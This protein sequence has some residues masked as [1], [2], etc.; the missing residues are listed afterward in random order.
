MSQSVTTSLKWSEMIEPIDLIRVSP[1]LYHLYEANAAADPTRIVIEQALIGSSPRSW[2]TLTYQ[3]LSFQIAK[4]R[5]FLQLQGIG[6]LSRCSICSNTCPEWLI[7]DLAVLSLGAAT[8]SIYTTLPTQD[9]AYIMKD[10]NVTVAIVENQTLVDQFLKIHEGFQGSDENWYPPHPLTHIICIQPCTAHPLVTSLSDIVA[11]PV[12]ENTT[13][14]CSATRNSFASLVYTSGSTGLPK[15]V[16]QTHGNHLANLEQVVQADV[17]GPSGSLFLYL[18][19]AHSFARLVGYLGLFTDTTLKMPAITDPVSGTLDLV[20]VSQDLRAANCEYIPSIPRLFEKI[21]MNI[22]RKATEKT[23]Q[24][25]VLRR[26]LN[27]AQKMYRATKTKNS[28]S[29]ITWAIYHITDSIRTKLRDTIFGTKLIH[30]ISG[31]A[32]LSP[33]VTEF[34]AAL[35]I[36]I[37]QGYGLTETCVATNVNRHN[38]NRIGTVGPVFDGIEMK[39]TTEHEIC[40]RGPN[41]ANGYWEKPEETK[42]S[43][44]SDGWFHTGDLGSVDEDGFLTITGRKKEVIVS[45]GGKKIA[46]QKVEKLLE[47]LPGISHAVLFGNDRPYCV[48]LLTMSDPDSVKKDNNAQHH[49]E[50]WKKIEHINEQLAPFERIRRARIIFEEFSVENGL[51]T[52]T[53]KIKRHEIRDRYQDLIWEM[54]DNVPHP[55]SVSPT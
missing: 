38:D 24:G 30:A 7:S 32:K 19:L 21:K 20:S 53:H 25:W 16:I 36:I 35:D 26:T 49:A 9:I 52:P 41:V 39:L 29:P 14:Q 31:G 10:A 34:F 3:E 47:N 55:G 11:G 46:P 4:L 51:L 8:V 2:S 28:I 42:A 1:S 6:E 37:L 33:D 18:P 48:A 45:A 54:Y 27:A 43:W 17:F 23:V 13:F 15:G 44:D 5:S 22:E 50:L 40:F 12:G